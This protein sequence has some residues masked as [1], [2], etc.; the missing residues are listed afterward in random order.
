M[1]RVSQTH[2]IA[3]GI[4]AAA[5][6]IYSI[7]NIV[8]AAALFFSQRAGTGTLTLQTLSAQN[9]VLTGRAAAGASMICAHGSKAWRA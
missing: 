9:P 4:P 3:P 8:S 7:F 1:G 2:S 6:L 5:T